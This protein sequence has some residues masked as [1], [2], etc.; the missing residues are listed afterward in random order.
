[1]YPKDEINNK[2]YSENKTMELKQV[3]KYNSQ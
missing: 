3:G 2:I 1:M